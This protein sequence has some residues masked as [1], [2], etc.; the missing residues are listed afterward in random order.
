MFRFIHQLNL[1]LIL[2]LK[3][4]R[5][6]KINE[7][8]ATLRMKI[9]LEEGKQDPVAYRIKF[10]AH[11]RTGD[12]WY[13]ICCLNMINL[14]YDHEEAICLFNKK[15]INQMKNFFFKFIIL[16]NAPIFT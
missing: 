9:T 16:T 14:I 12:Q 8:E 1:I 5:K 6:G 10:T 4:M 11:H 7:G 13:M 15:N 3:D 2:L